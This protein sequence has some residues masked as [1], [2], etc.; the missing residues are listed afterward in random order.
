MACGGSLLGEVIATSMFLSD[1]YSQQWLNTHLR[2]QVVTGR[3][4][5]AG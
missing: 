1:G 5:M 4:L 3:V 2:Y